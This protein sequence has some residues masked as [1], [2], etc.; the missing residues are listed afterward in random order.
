M[1]EGKG[2]VGLVFSNRALLERTS[3]QN[4]A[5][6]GTPRNP[7]NMFLAPSKQPYRERPFGPRAL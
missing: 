1:V 5:E 2:F 3:V 7:A 6:H 4:A